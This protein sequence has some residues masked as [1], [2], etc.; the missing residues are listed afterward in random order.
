MRFHDE[1]LGTPNATMKEML[2]GPEP[3]LFTP[4]MVMKDREPAK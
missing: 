3:K 1:V 2:S 4:W